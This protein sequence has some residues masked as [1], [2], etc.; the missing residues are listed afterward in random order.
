MMTFPILPPSDDMDIHVHGAWAM[1]DQ[2]WKLEIEA[3]EE[4][5]NAEAVG[6]PQMNIEGLKRKAVFAENET[7]NAVALLFDQYR[8]HL[9]AE[10]KA[11]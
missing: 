6:A 10:Q 5:R 7:R 9:A 4:L 11:A 3:A 2:K 1:A 8:D